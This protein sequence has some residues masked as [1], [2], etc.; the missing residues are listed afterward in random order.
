MA[1]PSGDGSLYRFFLDGRFERT[2]L[3]QSSQ[4]H[5]TMTVRPSSAE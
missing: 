2:G 5:C 4:Y 1:P 3:I